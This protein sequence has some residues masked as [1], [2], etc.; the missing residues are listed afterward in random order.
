MSKSELPSEKILS[1]MEAEGSEFQNYGLIQSK[2]IADEFKSSDVNDF[3]TMTYMAKTSIENLKNLE[4]S[5]SM[6]IN[7]YVELYNSKI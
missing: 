5:S 7:K 4:E 6:D 1:D 2:K 3:S